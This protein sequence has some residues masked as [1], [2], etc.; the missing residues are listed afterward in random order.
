MNR[1]NV[2]FSLG[3]SGIALSRVVRAQTDAPSTTV[4]LAP[5]GPFPETLLAEIERGLRAELRV[6]VVRV[7]PF[8]LPA[9]ALYAPRRRYRAERLLD[10]LR[11]HMVAPATRILGVTGHLSREFIHERHEPTD[12]VADAAVWFCLEGILA[13]DG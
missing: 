6:S 7:G 4:G 12:E 10:F 11:P 13:R 9:A 8:A 3:L 1:R 2:L 5:L